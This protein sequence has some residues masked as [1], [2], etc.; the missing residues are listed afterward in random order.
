MTIHRE[1]NRIMIECDSCDEIFNGS[2]DDFAE[3][4][5]EAKADGWKAAKIVGE[6]MHGCARCGSPARE[7]RR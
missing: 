7:A 5:D 4:W 3:V 6:W 1:P 2:S